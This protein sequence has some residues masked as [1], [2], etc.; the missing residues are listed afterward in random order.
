[1][2]SPSWEVGALG[3]A[4]GLQE[5]Q[6]VQGSVVPP[7]HPCPWSGFLEADAEMEVG[8]SYLVG[9]NCERKEETLGLDRGR[10]LAVMWA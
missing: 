7:M 8:I 10:L 6:H 1:M 4:L 2:Q 5:P 3:G 9:I